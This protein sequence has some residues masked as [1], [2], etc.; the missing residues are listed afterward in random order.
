MGSAAP[1]E[2]DA[3]AAEGPWRA[4][5][6]P[7]MLAFVWLP[8]AAISALHYGTGMEHAWV[9]DILRRS[10]YLPIVIAAFLGGLR[11]AARGPR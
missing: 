3:R 9:H 2:A 5:V 8:I 11:G 10:Y 4:L 7:R 6:S 1:A